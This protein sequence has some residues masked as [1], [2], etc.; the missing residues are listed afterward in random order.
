MEC[1]ERWKS[2]GGDFKMDSGLFEILAFREAKAHFVLSSRRFGAEFDGFVEVRNRVCVLL[3]LSQGRA[4]S[5]LCKIEVGLAG[6]DLTKSD[7]RFLTPSFVEG[8]HSGKSFVGNSNDILR[9]STFDRRICSRA[10]FLKA[11]IAQ[12]SQFFHLT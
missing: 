3:L 1:G 10:R 5:V 12:G 2:A 8:L 9:I 11:H 4:Q 6:E 7:D